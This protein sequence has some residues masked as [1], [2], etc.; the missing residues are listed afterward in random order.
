MF[1][2][3]NRNGCSFELSGRFRQSDVLVVKWHKHTYNSHT[4]GYGSRLVVGNSNRCVNGLYL[5]RDV[6][7]IPTNAV[8][9]S[10]I[11]FN[12]NRM[13]YG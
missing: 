8:E 13:C 4:N 3:D 7:D 9:Q 11:G 1:W 12:T 6:Y 2:S 10:D 5:Y